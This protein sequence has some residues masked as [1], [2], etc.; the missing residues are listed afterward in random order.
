MNK[1]GLINFSF[2]L[3]FCIENNNKTLLLPS[4]QL[5]LVELSFQLSSHFV[6]FLNQLFKKFKYKECD[7]S[8]VLKI[9]L[10]FLQLKFVCLY[11]NGNLEAGHGYNSLK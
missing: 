8:V 11:M 5:T 7:K 2:Q 9:K 3:I 4:N 10:L 1:K 6:C